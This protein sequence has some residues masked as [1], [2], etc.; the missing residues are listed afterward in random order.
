MV[1]LLG[2]GPGDPGLLTRAGAD[3]LARAEVVVY[4]RL[5]SPELLDL[6]PPSAE[7]IYAG[8]APGGHAMTQ[9]QIN[10]TLV[11]QGRAGRRVVRLKGG[12]PF[13]FGRGGEEAAALAEAGVPYCVVPGITAAIGACAYAGIPLTDRR[14]ASSVALVTGHEDPDRPGSRMNWSALAGIDTVVFYMGVG[15]LAH[16]AER[17]IEAGRPPATPTALVE[18]GTTPA[19]RTVLATLASVAERAAEQRVQAPALLVVGEVARLAERLAW[20]APLPLAGRT[21]LVTRSRQ[22]ASALAGRLRELGAAVIEAPTIAIE[23][24]E[25]FSTI[26]AALA[27]LGEYGL[28]AFTSANGVE[29]FLARGRTLGLDGRALA[30]VRLAAVGPATAEA[31]RKAFLEPDVVPEVFTAD[32]LA[33]ALASLGDLAGRR[34]LLARA[35][36]ARPALVEALAAAGAIVDDI[37]FYRTVAPE[38]LPPEALDALENNRVDWITFTSS[39]TVTN[40]LELLPRRPGR[41]QRGPAAGAPLPAA[42]RLASIGPITSE[43]LREHGLEPTVEASPHDIPGLLQAILA[44]EQAGAEGASA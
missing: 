1:V 37:A 11:E 44:A 19:Q 16:I 27:R 8:K 23:P 36:I 5:A 2:G 21:V 14:W 15:N 9:E 6:A 17:L 32:A 40:F 26:D 10:A 12:D 4:D 41:A 43:T 18:R 29:A 28:V 38:A 31:M 22:Q 30:G 7:R 3:W 33:A 13:V 34:V 25:D 42:V 39:S 20:R 24:P 35:D